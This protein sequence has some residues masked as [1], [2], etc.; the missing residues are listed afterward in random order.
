[1]RRRRLLAFLQDDKP[2]WKDKDHP[3]LTPGTGAWVSS[4]RREGESRILARKPTKKSAK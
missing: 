1:L 3:D 4:L 2:A